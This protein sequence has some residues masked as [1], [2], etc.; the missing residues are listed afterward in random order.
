MERCLTKTT[1]ATEAYHNQTFTSSKR[2]LRLSRHQQTTASQTKKPTMTTNNTKPTAR[3]F[4]KIDYLI[5]ALFF[6]GG[7]ETFML[8]QGI[9]EIFSNLAFLTKYLVATFNLRIKNRYRK[10][11]VILLILTA[12]WFM[13]RAP[14]PNTAFFSSCWHV[15]MPAGFIVLVLN[16]FSVSNLLRQHIKLLQCFKNNYQ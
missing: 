8:Y 14:I 11:P 6:L 3:L 9:K 2:L 16:I 5:T 15:L 4:C 12:Y 10:L 13:P 7:I 1:T